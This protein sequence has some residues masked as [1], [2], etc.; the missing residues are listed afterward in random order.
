MSVRF[1]RINLLRFGII[2][3]N[4][5]F[6]FLDVSYFVEQAT[7]FFTFLAVV[8]RLNLLGIGTLVILPV[9]LYR[10][11]VSLIL[12]LSAFVS[13]VDSNTKSTPLGSLM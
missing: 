3:L 6:K 4:Q 11:M 1:A 7:Y 13:G 10:A 2:P 5:L 12:F 9:A 8:V